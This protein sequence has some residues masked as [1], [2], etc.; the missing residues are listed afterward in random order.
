MSD[1]NIKNENLRRFKNIIFSPDVP[2]LYGQGLSDYE[3]LVRIANAINDCVNTINSFDELAKELEKALND[4]DGYVKDEVI[5]AVQDLYDSGELAGIVGEILSNSMVGKY[6]TLDL[7]HMG[8]VTHLAHSYQTGNATTYNEQRYSVGQGGCVFKIDGLKYWVVVATRQNVNPAPADDGATVYVYRFNDEGDIFYLTSHHYSNLGHSNGCCYHDGYIYITPNS[9]ASGLTTDIHRISFDGE[10][11][12]LTSVKKT[13]PYVEEDDWID[14]P[15]SYNGNLYVVDRYMNVLLYDWDANTLTLAYATINGNLGYSSEGMSID[16]NFIYFGNS[17][18]NQLKR[19]NKALGVVDWVYQI[20]KNV[21]NQMWKCGELEHFSILDGVIYYLGMYNLGFNVTTNDYCVWHFYRQNLANHNIAP[22]NAFGGWSSGHTNTATVYVGGDLPSDTDDAITSIGTLSA[23]F[24][25][26]QHAI[27][28]V[29]G[30]NWIQK[31][32]IDIRQEPNFSNIDIR[33]T[34]PLVITGE[35]YQNAHSTATNIIKP[36]IGHVFIMRQTNVKLQNVGLCNR[37]PDNIYP[38]AMLDNVKVSVN[39]YLVNA[40]RIADA[41]A[42]TL[43]RLYF[44]TGLV[45][46]HQYIVHA[47]SITNSNVNLYQNLTQYFDS[48][49]SGYKD[50]P[51]YAWTTA[52]ASLISHPVQTINYLNASASSINTH[53]AIHY[54]ENSSGAYRNLYIRDDVINIRNNNVID[55]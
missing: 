3:I 43:S 52:R 2:A 41:S 31:A 30:N 24:P 16:D 45:S 49:I 29:E 14:F 50:T 12:G 42:V 10:N 13:A 48:N 25:S 9:Y 5:K 26:V 47:I 28:F 19:Y 33:T 23:P 21:N 17:A 15:C 39:D 6:S 46:N 34:K 1:N 20:P 11:L 53:G 18:Q 32:T 7:S 55:C 40:L 36:L 8:F 54:L 38:E 44:P 51:M 37:L 27:D 35:G 4:I 22:T